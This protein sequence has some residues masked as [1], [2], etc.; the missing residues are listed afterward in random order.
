MDDVVDIFEL[1]TSTGRRSGQVRETKRKG[2]KGKG[3]GKENEEHGC[4]HQSHHIIFGLLAETRGK[5]LVG[6]HS[7]LVGIWGVF[8]CFVSFCVGAIQALIVIIIIL[9]SI[10]IPFTMAGFL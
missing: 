3:K 2:R 10:F 6:F 4:C 5:G 9:Y 1:T 8:L 7:L